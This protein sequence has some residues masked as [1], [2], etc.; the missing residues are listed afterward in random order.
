MSENT[1]YFK[2]AVSPSP[3][4]KEHVTFGIFVRHFDLTNRESASRLYKSLIQSHGISSSR[5]DLLQKEYKIFCDNHAELFW[6]DRNLRVSSEICAK[7]AAV[8]LQ[9]LGLKQSII[10]FENLLSA[11]PADGGTCSLKRSIAEL[12]EEDEPMVQYARTDAGES[13]DSDSTGIKRK[14]TSSA[15]DTEDDLARVAEY[16]PFAHLVT[17]L[18]QK[19]E[20]INA[21]CHDVGFLSSLG[22]SPPTIQPLKLFPSTAIRQ[23]HEFAEEILDHW[24]TS[25][26][27][28]QNDCL[29]AMSGIINTLDPDQRPYFSAC[30]DIMSQSRQEDFL[31]VTE[32]QQTLFE[33]LQ[34]I[35]GNS[36][37]QKISRLRRYCSRR[38]DDLE[39]DKEQSFGWTGEQA[40]AKREELK[41]VHVLEFLCDE[42]LALQKIVNTSEHEDVLIWRGVARILHS[43]DVVIRV[44][45]LGSSSAGRDRRDNE[46]QFGGTE[47]GVRS[48]TIDILHQLCPREAKSPVEIVAWEAQQDT[49]SAE[50]L[51]VRIRNSIR[52]NVSMMNKL[53]PYLDSRFPCPAPIVLDIIGSRALAYLVRKIEPG[54]FGVG[55]IS[56][57]MIELPRAADEITRFLYNGSMSALLKVEQMIDDNQLTAYVN[58]VCCVAMVLIVAYHF[59]AVNATPTGHH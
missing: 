7:K 3:N 56:E 59:V 39:Q 20:M 50:T 30:Q 57:E 36:E 32:R 19:Y 31:T 18:Y 43:H 47:S 6:A 21:A 2:W 26:K 16:T 44:G 9:E 28:K 35:L 13:C 55:A 22:Y 34:R 14:S 49:A 1:K 40:D 45:E 41:V 12:Q 52:T 5:K 48:R 4:H 23:L 10:A 42:I 24:D 29:L 15:H 33:D 54:V 27:L 53:A 8:M 58:G 37:R 51:Q 46:E 17:R 11:F 25:S 38:R